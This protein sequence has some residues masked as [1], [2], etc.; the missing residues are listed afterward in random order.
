MLLIC[1][2]GI[3]TDPGDIHRVQQ[4]GTRRDI[5][6]NPPF[7]D[8][9]WHLVT[10]T[11]NRSANQVISYLDG[12]AVMTSD[13]SPS[14]TASFNAG[15]NTLVGGT[16]NGL[17]SATA[18]IDDLG[19]WAR[20]L[21]PDE[22]AGIYG[23]G[24]GGRSLLLAVPGQA[25]YSATRRLVLK[26][27]DSLVFV[28]NSATDRWHENLQSFREM[29]GHLVAQQLDP[30]TIPM[31]L[32]YNKRDL[33]DVLEVEALNRGESYIEH[34]GL[35]LACRGCASDSASPIIAIT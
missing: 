2:Q 34:I 31:V 21:A 9:N 11:F 32:Q 7:S 13:I 28:A 35:C 26:G 12:T 15:L 6:L 10:F 30:N 1:K 17:Y 5:E 33:P 25:M 22:I 20:V 16:G 3:A 24:L 29:R 8:G 27:A 18:D 4:R 14:G 19:V 23:A